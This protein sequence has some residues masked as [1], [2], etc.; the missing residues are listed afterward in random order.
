MS[1]P[2]DRTG[3]SARTWWVVGVVGVLAMSAVAV[4]FGLSATLGR[5]HWV[6]T[7]HQIVADDRVDVRFDLTR[8]PT[9]SVVCLLEA[10]DV[11]HTVV[12]SVE[13]TI[14]PVAS[15]PSRHVATV[16]TAGPAVTGY[17]E[18]CRYADED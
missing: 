9:R 3:S 14:G 4:W 12:G 2:T 17:V 1:T 6:D 7:G 11:R 15:S 8:D 5:V 13:T 18:R 16:R 10:Q